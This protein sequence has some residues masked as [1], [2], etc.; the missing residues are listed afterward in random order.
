M[1]GTSSTE[2]SP[3]EC[4]YCHGT[5]KS[6]QALFAGDVKVEYKHHFSALNYYASY[7]TCEEK[8]ELIEHREVDCPSCRGTG[9]D[10]K[11]PAPRGFS[12]SMEVAVREPSK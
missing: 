5:G 10:P 12:E 4:V 9:R 11:A 8:G 6:D 2:A 7:T 3:F 1:T